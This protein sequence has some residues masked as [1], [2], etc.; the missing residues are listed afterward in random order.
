MTIDITETEARV[1]QK[2]ID[3]VSE[4]PN[5]QVS[6]KHL[7]FNVQLQAYLHALFV[8]YNQDPF[9]ATISIKEKRFVPYNPRNESI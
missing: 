3:N 9:E 7:A 1:I 8:K 2:F 5:G 4:F 6:G